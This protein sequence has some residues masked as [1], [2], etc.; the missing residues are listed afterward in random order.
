MPAKSAMRKGGYIV[1]R[2]AENEIVGTT[3]SRL[4]KIKDKILSEFVF[5]LFINFT[6][7]K[8]SSHI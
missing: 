2:S 6:F 4:D 5:F 7:K 8:E 1:K 3:C